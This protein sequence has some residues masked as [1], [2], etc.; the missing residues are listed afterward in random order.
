MDSVF[1][2]VIFVARYF[3]TVEPCQWPIEQFHERLTALVLNPLRPHQEDERKAEDFSHY[4]FHLPNRFPT[5]YMY[6]Y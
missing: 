2:G 5:V 3:S 4:T 6:M 1:T